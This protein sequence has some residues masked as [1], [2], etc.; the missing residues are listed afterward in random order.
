MLGCIFARVLATAL[1]LSMLARH[2]ASIFGC[3][4]AEIIEIPNTDLFQTLLSHSAIRNASN[5]LRH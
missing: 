4:L 3:T 1:M 5:A 2:S